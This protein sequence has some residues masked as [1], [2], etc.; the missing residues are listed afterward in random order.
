MSDATANGPAWAKAKPETE[1][2]TLPAFDP[3]PVS[4]PVL[5]GDA[6]TPLGQGTLLSL[7]MARAADRD[8]GE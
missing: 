3:V 1:S 4:A 7:L 2:V 5:I 8:D 6:V